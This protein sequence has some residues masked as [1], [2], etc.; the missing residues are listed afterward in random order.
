MG[1]LPK[2]LQPIVYTL[3]E[4]GLSEAFEEFVGSSE[5]DLMSTSLQHLSKVSELS[6]ARTT[7]YS[8]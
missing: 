5:V 6:S 8:F 4:C 1:D 3:L 2:H 7:L